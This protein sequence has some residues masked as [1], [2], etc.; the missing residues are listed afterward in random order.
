M[1]LTVL[2]GSVLTVVGLYA[3]LTR[4]PEP[5]T[6]IG[7][8]TTSQLDRLT[9]RTGTGYALTLT[10]LL[11]LTATTSRPAAWWGESILDG[12][13]PTG[14]YWL[15]IVALL[16]GAV[17]V[18]FAASDRVACSG[19]ALT[20]TGGALLFG[21]AG[22]LVA[23]IAL[24]VA[25]AAG[26]WAA[27]CLPS[28]REQTRLD[29]PEPLLLT[30]T[31]VTILALT[32]STLHRSATSEVRFAETYE[33]G[34]RTLPRPAV[35]RTQL[36]N[37]SAAEATGDLEATSMNPSALQP[38]ASPWHSLGTYALLM[39]VTAIGVWQSWNRGEFSE[40]AEPD[41]ITAAG[42][43][44]DAVPQTPPQSPG[45]RP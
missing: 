18:T 19:I 26:G 31:L 45:D 13:L 14:V 15:G 34:D 24:I 23:G 11:I 33:T 41:G 25:A 5:A 1:E 10:G 39:L 12:S 21:L 7:T 37:G 3:L 36:R 2:F 8:A 27:R 30:A 20:G 29:F 35:A 43:G 32:A 17:T 42:I 38:T 22:D 44:R 28:L 6:E 40:P 16:G 9:S 4:R